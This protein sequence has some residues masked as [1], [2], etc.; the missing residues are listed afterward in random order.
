M[1]ACQENSN[2]PDDENLSPDQHAELEQIIAKYNHVFR[3]RVGCCNKY[4]HKL[5]FKSIPEL[6][7]AKYRA[8]PGS[9]KAEIDEIIAGWKRNGIIKLSVSPHRVALVY[10]EK[11]NGKTRPCG[12]FRD[13]NKC[14]HMHMN[15]VPK[16][17]EIKALLH[18]SKFFSSLD[19]N[20]GFLQ[21]PLHPESQEFCAFSYSGDHFQYVRVPY[22][23]KDSMLAFIA[24]LRRVLAGTEEFAICYVDDL[25]IFSKTWQEHLQHVDIMLRKIQGAEMTLNLRKCQW[26]LAQTK[27]LGLSINREG[28]EPDRDRIQGI[29]DYPAPSSK[30]QVQSFLGMI[31]YYRTF[32]PTI[33]RKAEPLYNLTANNTKFIWDSVCQKAFEE[34]K[35]DLCKATLQAYPDFSKEFYVICDAS[36]AGIGSAV[37]QLKDPQTPMPISFNSRTLSASE[38]NYTITELELLAIIHGLKKNSHFLIGHKVIVLTDHIAATFMRVRDVYPARIIRWLYYFEKFDIEMIHIAGAKNQVADALSRFHRTIFGENEA[39]FA[40][41][42]EISMNLAE[43]ENPSELMKAIQNLPTLQSKDPTLQKL[44]TQ[45]SEKI[46]KDENGIYWLINRHGEPKIF[47]PEIIRSKLLA[48]YHTSYHHPGSGK[49]VTLCRRNFAWPGMV[50]Q[51]QRFVE[52]CVQCKVSKPGRQLTGD[53]YRELPK[54]PNEQLA[55]DYFGPLPIGRAGVRYILVIQDQFSKFTKL[56]A[57]KHASSVAAVKYIRTWIGEYGKPGSILSDNGPAFRANIYR[58]I[59]RKEKIRI[60]YIATHNPAANPAERIM[61]SIA[62]M[63]RRK[64]NPKQGKWPTVIPEME[65]RLNLIEHGSTGQI[66]AEVFLGV[67]IDDELGDSLRPYFNKKFNYEKI[68]IN[69]RISLEANLNRRKLYVTNPVKLQPG[70]KVY[71]KNHFLSNAARNFSAKLAPKFSG[72]FLVIRELYPNYYLL[73]NPDSKEEVRLNVRN[74][75]K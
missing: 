10:A 54:N 63:I 36:L 1:A 22:G 21:I 74:I 34:L 38:K 7:Q 45:G 50:A 55:V 75:K 15:E 67:P 11:S 9:K 4:L 32:I 29:L 49:L 44:Q 6:L 5:K 46:S 59:M 66:P 26:G 27:Y 70:Q 72:P 62:E 56:Y 20:E 52:N 17:D 3:E 57:T 58:K 12:D 68:L 71:V 39:D 65:E 30:K 41:S 31:N 51:A 53:L 35:M 69:T 37:Y 33:A 40:G 42:R 48:F 24:A 47:T 61:P 25:L 23:T 43:E 8:P 2:V 28:T 19:F 16:L 73:R 14:L 13:L 60:R 64:C 18:G